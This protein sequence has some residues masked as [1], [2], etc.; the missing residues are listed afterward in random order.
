MITEL[1]YKTVEA[2]FLFRKKRR[3][4]NGKIIPLNSEGKIYLRLS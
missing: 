3:R 2:G 4:K 1:A